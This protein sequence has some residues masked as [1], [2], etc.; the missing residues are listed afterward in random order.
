MED[1][2]HRV[3]MMN[4]VGERRTESRLWVLCVGE[5]LSYPARNLLPLLASELDCYLITAERDREFATYY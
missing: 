4:E 2:Q 5:G 1:D 3:S